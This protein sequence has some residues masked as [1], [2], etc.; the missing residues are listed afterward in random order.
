MAPL[1]VASLGVNVC[2]ASRG[3]MPR[4]AGSPCRWVASSLEERF[5]AFGALTLHVSK[6]RLDADEFSTPVVV[7]GPACSGTGDD[8]F[9]KDPGLGFSGGWLETAARLSSVAS[10]PP[11]TPPGVGVRLA[12]TAVGNP[13]FWLSGLAALVI[14]DSFALVL[15]ANVSLKRLPAKER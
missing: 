3:E 9:D 2:P 6:A 4:G 13:G 15:L 11:W 12:T 5:G 8:G 7:G 1:L 14:N 10:Q